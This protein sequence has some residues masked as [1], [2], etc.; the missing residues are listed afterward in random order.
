MLYANESLFQSPVLQVCISAWFKAMLVAPLWTLCS[1]EA[2]AWLSDECVIMENPLC[3]YHSDCNRGMV[4]ESVRGDLRDVILC[5][6]NFYFKIYL[7]QFIVLS[8]YTLHFPCVI[9][10]KFWRCCIDFGDVRTALIATNYSQC[11]VGHTSHVAP[12]IM[13]RHCT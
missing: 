7:L 1:C 11:C 10:Q 13:N 12:V 6:C 3:A 2:S 8:T 5:P 9:S 4:R